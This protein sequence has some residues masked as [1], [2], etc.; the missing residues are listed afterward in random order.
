MLVIRKSHT[1]KGGIDYTPNQSSSISLQGNFNPSERLNF[2][3]IYFDETSIDGINKYYRL[4]DSESNQSNWDLDLSAK[5][6][7]ESGLHLDFITSK[8]QNKSDKFD[9]FEETDSV[10]L[11]ELLSD[12][13]PIYEQISSAR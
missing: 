6:D 1:F 7:W 5:K 8:S 12:T 10:N 9:L 11:N 2:D 13:Y 3:T 4:T